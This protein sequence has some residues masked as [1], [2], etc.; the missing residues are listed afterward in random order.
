MPLR[1]VLNLPVVKPKKQLDKMTSAEKEE[2]KVEKNKIKHFENVTID[3]GL[4]DSQVYQR[5]G[6]GNL[7]STGEQIGKSTLKIILSNV[8][9]FFNIKF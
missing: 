4:N 8:Y 9:T 2:L 7:N 5:I 6:E 3:I 1:L